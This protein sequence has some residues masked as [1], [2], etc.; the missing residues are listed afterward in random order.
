M[1]L[2]DEAFR[3]VPNEHTGHQY[4]ESTEALNDETPVMACLRSKQR[5]SQMSTNS[6]HSNSSA[7]TISIGDLID[8]D[9]DSLCP[10]NAFG[11]TGNV[12]DQP[13]AQL[14]DF[15][16]RISS[17]RDT[18]SN[19]NDSQ[20]LDDDEASF[21]FVMENDDDNG[22]PKYLETPA[23]SVYQD[24]MESL[25][26]S[27]SSL[28]E[29]FDKLS[30]CMEKTNHTRSL[31]KHLSSTSNQGVPS[32]SRTVS[33]TSSLRSLGRGISRSSSNNSL[34]SLGSNKSL[35]SL[36]KKSKNKT[37]RKLRRAVKSD[38]T[39]GGLIRRPM[40]QIILPSRSEA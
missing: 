39:R 10:L 37:S 36:G 27:I 9:D 21:G 23:V 7:N 20:S 30:A 19:Y 29:A 28:N 24:P 1:L 38:L 11:D 33:R 40:P 34:N 3:S 12:M 16:V 18:V 32:V 26:K 31:L 13:D 35:G 22:I 14:V 6:L 4:D 5:N 25:N 15:A 17:H 8:G 2:E